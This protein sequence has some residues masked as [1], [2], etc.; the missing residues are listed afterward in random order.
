MSPGRGVVN[1]R[2]RPPSFVFWMAV[3]VIAVGWVFYAALKDSLPPSDLHIAKLPLYIGSA[4]AGII[5]VGAT[6]RLW[7]RHLWRN[8]RHHQLP[9]AHSSSR[10]H[11]RRPDPSHDQ[12]PDCDTA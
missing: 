5:L 2:L 3:L 8:R 10:R 4:L 11:R 9:S 12:R 1:F 6:A 7:Y